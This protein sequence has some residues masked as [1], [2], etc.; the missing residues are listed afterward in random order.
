MT[1]ALVR[2][3]SD[4]PRFGFGMLLRPWRLPAW[5]R[6]KSAQM[7]R[8]HLQHN[9]DAVAPYLCERDRVL[10][11]GAWNGHL[12]RELRDRLGCQVL[13]VDVVDEH[14]TDVPFR[15]FDGQRLPL[16]RGETFDAIL[17]MYVLHHSAHDLDLLQQARQACREGGVVLVAEDMVETRRQRLVTIGFH[18]WLLLFT[19]MGWKGA[20]RTQAAWRARFARAGLTI[21]EIRPLGSQGGRRLFPLNIMYVLEPTALPEHPPPN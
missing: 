21:R 8:E 11:I 9:Y 14:E 4:A 6:H 3:Q 7:Y 12:G 16:E 15:V 10:D 5:F 2:S 19:F 1:N 17:F 13:D 18:I 20:F